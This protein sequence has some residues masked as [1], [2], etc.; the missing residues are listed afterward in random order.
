[1]YGVMIGSKRIKKMAKE[2]V[3]RVGKN[4]FSLMM[5]HAINF[6]S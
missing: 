1:M 5:V 6:K 4:D 3:E 2:N